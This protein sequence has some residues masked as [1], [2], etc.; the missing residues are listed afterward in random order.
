MANIHDWLI[1]VLTFLGTIFAGAGLKW[2]EGV[3]KKAKDKDD[4]ATNLRNE[5]RTDLAALKA[6]NQSNEK[7]A[8]QWR[9]KYYAQ[10]ENTLALAAEVESLRRQAKAPVGD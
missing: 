9:D 7:E 10:L 5:L 1:P 3:L 6:E 4:T 8:D 2:I